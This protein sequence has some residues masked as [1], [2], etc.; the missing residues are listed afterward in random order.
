MS[1]GR[2]SQDAACFS[3]ERTKYLMLSKSMP[4]RSAPQRGIGLRSNRSQRLEPE[5]EHP[6][7]LVLQGGDVGDHVGGQAASCG[8]AGGVGVGPAEVV[9]AERRERL[10]LGERGCRF[11]SGRHSDCLPLGIVVPGRSA[12]TVVVVG[13]SDIGGI[14]AERGWCTRSRPAR[15]WPAA[16][17]GCRAARRTPAVSA[18]HSSGN[19]AAT[20]ATGQ[21]CW[22]SCAPVPASPGLRSVAA[23]GEHLGQRVGPRTGG[24]GGGDLLRGRSDQL[25]GPAARRSPAP[26]PRRRVR[27][28]SAGRPRRGRRSRA[29]SGPGRRR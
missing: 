9:A 27:P 12:G 25:D 7:R 24:A 28:G 8:G 14:P 3:V 2:S 15:W 11:R 21:W 1:A 16:A 20:W 17:R 4:E 23:G 5:L 13:A 10:L 6:L 22:H 18:S 29:R 19:S 26:R